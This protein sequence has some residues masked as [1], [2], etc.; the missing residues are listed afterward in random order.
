MQHC[1]LFSRIKKMRCA[2]SLI[3]IVACSLLAFQ[4]ANGQS[5]CTWE[6]R[7]GRAHVSPFDAPDGTSKYVIVT[8]GK[9]GLTDVT[10]ELRK[11]QAVS[12]EDVSSIRELTTLG[13]VVT[14]KMSRRALV[15]LCRQEELDEFIKYV[16]LDQQVSLY[17]DSSRAIPPPVLI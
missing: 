13:N 4:D 17:T 3:L 16:E 14:A 7:L 5:E 9:E 6:L 2:W 11:I 15:W 12:K 10:N 8:T 1:K